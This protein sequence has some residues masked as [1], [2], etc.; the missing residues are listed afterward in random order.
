MHNVSLGLVSLQ[1]PYPNNLLR[2]VG[3]SII[4]QRSY[5]FVVDVDLLCNGNLYH[6]FLELAEHLR[7][8]LINN[9]KV[10][11]ATGLLINPG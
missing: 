6:G 5:V 2:N 7:L 8:P 3:R 1:V 9:G 4:S 10:Q 11:L